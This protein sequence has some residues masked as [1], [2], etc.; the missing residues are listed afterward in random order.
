MHIAGTDVMILNIFSP[1]DMAKTIAFFVQTTASFHKNEIITS[2]FVKNSIFSPK[3]G[4]IAEN[5]DHI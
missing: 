3:I 2:V 1:K 5:C 4:K